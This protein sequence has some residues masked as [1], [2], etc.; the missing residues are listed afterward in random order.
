MCVFTVAS[1]STRRSAISPFVRPRVTS[2]S[3]SRSRGLKSVQPAPRVTW[4][5]AG[6]ESCHD[7]ASDGRCQQ[8]V[9]GRNGSY[10]RDELMRRRVLQEKAACSGPQCL[11]EVLVQVEGR[12]DH[13]PRGLTRRMTLDQPA[14]GLESIRP[15]HLNVH[16]HDLRSKGSQRDVLPP[17]R[18]LPHRRPRDPVRTPGSFAVRSGSLLDRR[19]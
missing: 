18:R 3:T 19:R 16:E 1:P 7:A 5:P 14:R 17:P 2:R 10:R 8:G 12:Q 6:C 15:R 13:D 11:E 4:S 9:T